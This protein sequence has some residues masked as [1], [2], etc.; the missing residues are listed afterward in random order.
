VHT[1]CCTLRWSV[2]WKDCP[3]KNVQADP[4]PS[5]KSRIYEK[6]NFYKEYYFTILWFSECELVKS[7]PSFQFELYLLYF[8][9][10]LASNKTG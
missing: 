7:V 10:V 5:H 8:P 6:N 2:K 1:A 9:F 3:I 4:K